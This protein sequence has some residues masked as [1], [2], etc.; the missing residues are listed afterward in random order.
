MRYLVG[1]Q[2]AEA[3]QSVIFNAARPE[4]GLALGVG[5]AML[6]MGA[7]TVLAQLSSALNKIWGVKADPKREDWRAF[8][9]KRLLCFAT[10]LAVGF[11]LL[12]SLVLSAVLSSMGQWLGG[13]SDDSPLAWQFVN[14]LALF[15]VI[16]LLFAMLF[17][18][19]P[20]TEV[21]W[22]PVWVGASGT[23]LLFTVGKHLIGIHLGHSSLGSS[24]GAAGSL[25][26]FTAWIY[27][28][29]LLVFLGAKI[30]SV[31]S[32]RS[33]GSPAPDFAA[34]GVSKVG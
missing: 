6:L 33:R 8:L 4:S 29:S 1:E 16:T 3:I 17:K 22:R 24:L 18:Y 14:A 19:V 15:L 7:S 31:H 28:A 2:G 13:G 32:R 12:V 10:V 30:T 34:S 11:L 27:Y 25:V 20:D 5:I 9:R 26:V 21:S 23:S